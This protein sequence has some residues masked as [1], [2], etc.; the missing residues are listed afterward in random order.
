M[1]QIGSTNKMSVGIAKC[2]LMEFLPNDTAITSLVPGLVVDGLALEGLPLPIVDRYM[3]LGILMIPGLTIKSMV[4]HRIC[5]G[6]AR[7]ASVIPYCAVSGALGDSCGRFW[8]RKRR[9]KTVW[10]PVIIG[11]HWLIPWRTKWRRP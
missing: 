6:R 10:H 3:Y 8:W 11:N 1:S 5:Q 2:G 4:D 9:S 7:V